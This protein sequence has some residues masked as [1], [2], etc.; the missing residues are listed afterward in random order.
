MITQHIPNLTAQMII[1]NATQMNQHVQPAGPIK[2]E[3]IL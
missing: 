1:N 3:A 2:A